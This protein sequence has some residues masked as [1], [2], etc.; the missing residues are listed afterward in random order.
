VPIVVTIEEWI[1]IFNQ[2]DL[3]VDLSDWKI[4]DTL[5]KTTTYI[6]PDGTKISAKGFLVLNRPTTKITL[7]ND[8]DGLNLIQPDGKIID[9]ISFEKAPIGQSYNKIENS[10]TWSNNLTPGS[11]NNISAEI[12]EEENSGGAKINEG[13]AAVGPIS[14]LLENQSKKASNFSL[15]L[16][17]S[18]LIAIFSGITILL[19]KKKFKKED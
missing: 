17:I 2:N 10:W 4:S 12:S 18:F 5:G 8:N 9:T 7:N 14:G 1:E 16:S 19:L 3:E 11:V 6:F 13:L 15:I